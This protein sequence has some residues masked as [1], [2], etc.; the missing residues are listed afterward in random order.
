MSEIPRLDPIAVQKVLSSPPFAVVEGVINIRDVGGYPIQ[1]KPSLVVKPGSIFRSGDLSRITD[2]GKKQIH[3]LGIKTIFDLRSDLEI[4]TYK[5]QPVGI[6]GVET[7][8]VPV[9]VQGFDPGNIV[10]TL[11]CWQAL[12]WS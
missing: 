4:Q 2:L 3:A 1:S 6:D 10:A 5:T 12:R 8:R 7:V 9:V 11:V